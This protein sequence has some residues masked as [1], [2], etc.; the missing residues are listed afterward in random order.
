MKRNLI[1]LLVL[2]AALGGGGYLLAAEGKDA[3]SLAAKHKGSLL[4]AEQVN[5]SFQG[6]GGKIIDLAAKEEMKVSKGDVLM[7]LD[8]TD[9]DLQLQKAQADI[10]VTAIKVKQSEDALNVAQDKL[11]NAL[12]QAQIGVEQARTSQEQ[13]LEGA[14]SEDIERQK[15]AVA[16]ATEAHTHALKLYN[17]LLNIE[18]TYDKNPYAYK[19]HRDA[20]ENARSQLSTL[21]NA[22]DQQQQALNKMLNG[23]SQ[24]DKQQASLLTDKANAILEQNMLTGQDIANQRIG[25]DTLIKQQEQQNI[26]VQSLQVQKERMVLKAPVDGKVARIIPKAGENVGSGTPLIVLE[27]GKLYFDM[28]VD[29]RQVTKLQP[30]GTVPVRFAALPDQLT[31]RIQ[32]VTA[33]PQFAGLRMSREKGTADLTMFQARIEVDRIDKLLPGMTAEVHIDEIAAR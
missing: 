21:E 8:P 24:Q 27:T 26:L 18:D 20:L 16:A 25:L 6:V 32:F 33:A 2:G 15:L 28:Y 31:G 14:R 4:T 23:A 9:I 12:K 17:Q 3:V 19:D 13:V 1:L 10:E 29:E 30:E 7:T 5:V 11:G 22:R